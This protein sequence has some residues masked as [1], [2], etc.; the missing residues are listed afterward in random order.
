MA[1]SV[2]T[3]TLNP[4][5]DKI[6]YVHDFRTGGDFRSSR[7]VLSAGGKGINVSRALNHLGVKNIATGFLGGAS[8]DLLQEKLTQEN[9][10]NSFLKIKPET[11][12]N[13]TVIGRKNKITRIL[14]PGPAVSKN[15]LKNFVRRF[16]LLLKT[17][18]MVVL[19]GS[20]T[21]GLPDTIYGELIKIAK[22]RK[23]KTILDTSGRP[24]MAGL[25]ARPFAVKPN[26]SEA[27]LIAGKKLNS[28][29][30]MN[31]AVKSLL[32]KSRMVVLS[33][34]GQGAMAGWRNQVLLASPPKLKIINDVGCGDSL[35]AGLAYALK[36]NLSFEEGVRFAVAAGSADAL[37]L[38]PGAISKKD[39]KKIL[40]KIIL[41]KF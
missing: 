14:E 27:Q 12:T 18:D 37:T 39:I 1:K 10:R 5:V 26:L 7:I 33:L 38:T 31:A 13:L 20:L 9:I 36:N 40:P 24:L 35:A 29:N 2:L 6:V 34:A 30:A 17:C 41:R 21:P 32:K 4:A 25:R 15:D 11:R 19:S 8:G 23:I 3:V 28:F 16:S 22:R